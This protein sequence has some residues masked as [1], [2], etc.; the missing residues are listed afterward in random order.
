VGRNLG[1]YLRRRLKV[2]EETERRNIFLR[3]LGEVASAVSSINESDR[4][5]LY[6]QLLAVARRKTATADKELNEQG[7]FVEAAEEFGDNVL[8]VPLGDDLVLK[9][10]AARSDAAAL[11]SPETG[12]ADASAAPSASTAKAARSK[13]KPNK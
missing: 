7:Q 5:S 3:Y 4:D 2:K 13:N 9:P 6:E 10:G 1:T 12:A 11:A 8:I